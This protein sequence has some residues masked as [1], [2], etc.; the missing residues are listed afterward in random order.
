MGLFDRLLGNSGTSENIEE[1]KALLKQA[2][3]DIKNGITYFGITLKKLSEVI[4]STE[5]IEFA[6]RT[7]EIYQFVQMKDL[8][9]SNLLLG[10]VLILK[11]FY[12]AILVH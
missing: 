12:I 5:K 7:I 3:P 4:S 9:L 11:I 2:N 10:V 8:F 6:V 1:I